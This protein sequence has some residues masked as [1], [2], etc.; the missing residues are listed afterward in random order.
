MYFIK[1]FIVAL[2]EICLEW[3]EGRP[4][5]KAALPL[6]GVLALLLVIFQIGLYLFTAPTL[7]SYGSVYGYL[8]SVR[9]EPLSGVSVLFL[10]DAD[11]VG[12]V[13]ETNSSGYYETGGI[14]PGQFNV[15]I[16][17]KCDKNLKNVT[18]A[19]ITAAKQ[20]LTSKAPEKFQSTATSGITADLK[21]GSNRFDID[22][23]TL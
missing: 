15:A 18:P 5:A 16:Q 3:L 6:I 7:V 13:A 17:P 1:D 10:D 2:W 12:V 23:S 19:D 21:R 22:L 20:T 14:V 11:G 4:K 9:G 8:K